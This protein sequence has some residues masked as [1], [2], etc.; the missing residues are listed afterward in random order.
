MGIPAGRKEPE[1]AALAGAKRE[2]LEETGYRAK[3]WKKL[4]RIY[5]SPGFFSEWMQLYLA[6]GLTSG[7]RSL[8]RMNI[9]NTA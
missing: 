5:V 3:R 8:T 9:L 1:E 6:E 7:N 2:L 4:L